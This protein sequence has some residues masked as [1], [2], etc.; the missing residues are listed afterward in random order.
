MLRVSVGEVR[1]PPVIAI[2]P[3]LC[4][5]ASFVVILTIPFFLP[6]LVSFA[7]VGVYQMSALYSTLGN[8]TP[9][10][11]FLAYFGVISHPGLAMCL[12]CCSFFHNICTLRSL[13]E[14]LVKNHA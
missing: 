4:M 7:G 3:A 2:A 5:L 8:A 12:I 13:A 10:N 6:V 1:R 14:M 9:M 11:S